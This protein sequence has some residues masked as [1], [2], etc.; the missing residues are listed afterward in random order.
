MCIPL[1]GLLLILQALANLFRDLGLA[2]P[3]GGREISV[4]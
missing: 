3:G 2:P 1:A 4:A